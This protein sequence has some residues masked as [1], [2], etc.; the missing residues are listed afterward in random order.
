MPLLPLSDMASSINPLI[1]SRDRRIHT[2]TIL[3]KR[4]A[5]QTIKDFTLK[6]VLVKRMSEKLKE[7]IKILRQSDN[8]ITIVHGELAKYAI[9]VDFRDTVINQGDLQQTQRALAQIRKIEATPLVS[10]NE[11]EQLIWLPTRIREQI[12]ETRW[13]KRQ[14]F[15]KF[16]RAR[17]TVSETDIEKMPMNE[18]ERKK[19]LQ[20]FK[21]A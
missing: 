10:A 9:E 16:W 13:D 19:I 4:F 12:L 2:T 3:T 21:G 17:V 5:K 6:K 15:L 20:A 14:A 11:K 1:C 8:V 7:Q 18:E